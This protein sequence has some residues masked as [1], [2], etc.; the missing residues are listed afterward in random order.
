MTLPDP[1]DEYPELRNLPV[2]A[3]PAPMPDVSAMPEEF[4][5]STILALRA[6]QEILEMPLD[7]NDPHFRAKLSAKASVS[8]GQIN[9]QLKADEQKL[10][11]QLAV[12]SYYDELKKALLEFRA[13]SGK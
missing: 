1:F 4:A 2:P 9:A 11:G 8:S 12:T 13:R 3:P 6:Q 5:K 7:E 10:R